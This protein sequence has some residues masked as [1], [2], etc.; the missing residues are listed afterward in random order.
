M[1]RPNSIFVTLCGAT[2]RWASTA[3]ELL[4]LYELLAFS[5][6]MLI[7]HNVS[8]N[9]LRNGRSDCHVSIQTACGPLL[10]ISIGLRHLFQWSGRFTLFKS[11]VRV[12]IYGIY[13]PC[14]RY[15]AFVVTQLATKYYQ[16]V[17]ASPFCH[18]RSSWIFKWWKQTFLR[19]W[20][21]NKGYIIAL[22]FVL[23]QQK[24]NQSIVHCLIRRKDLQ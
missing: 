24:R 11:E 10:V 2:F 7:G 14:L 6:Q 12:T 4:T 23:T 18:K 5:G 17:R 21:L 8:S 9:G 19:T 1:C 16:R 13:V 15:W 22:L 3:T 20:R